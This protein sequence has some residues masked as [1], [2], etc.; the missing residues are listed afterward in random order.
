MAR[1][2][3]IEYAGAIYHV[4]SRGD[5][6]EAIYLDRE[7]RER[8]VEA[9]GTACD[10]TGWRLHAY[11]LMT[12]HFHLLLETPEPNLVVG[13]K[14]LLGTYTQRFNL[15]HRMVGHLFQGRYKA[16]PVS[17]EEPEYFRRVGTY[18]HLNPV[19]AR[20]LQP[21]EDRL[22]D[23]PWS[24][25]PALGGAPS[26]RPEWLVAERLLSSLGFLDDRGGRRRFRAYMQESMA[27]CARV[28]TRQDQQEWGAMRRGW[29]VGGADFRDRLLDRVDQILGQGAKE[30]HRGEAVR[31]HGEREALRMI[32][33]GLDCLGVTEEELRCRR[34]SD[35]VKLILAWL[36]R[37]RTT[38]K[39]AWITEQLNMGHRS[40]VSNAV[41]RV[42][43][44]REAGLK[45]LQKQ[46]AKL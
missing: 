30:S 39:A 38:A 33:R 41:R 34:K 20:I 19:R 43:E 22:D 24:S 1:K 10:R 21:A 7:D 5:R 9:L 45:R 6:R 35:P 31:E 42:E 32:V 37:T 15:R 27:E 44:G 23:Y 40:A 26:R 14:W 18:I 11:V 3:R 25:Y 12:N 8:F 4:L 29:F 17:G 13:M 2:P 16:I 46:V 28:G 36:V